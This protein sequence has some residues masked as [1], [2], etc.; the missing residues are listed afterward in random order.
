MKS[1]ILFFAIFLLALVSCDSNKTAPKQAEKSDFDAFYARF[2]KDSL[3][4]MAHINFPLPGLPEHPDSLSNPGDFRWY[5]EDW[6]MHRPIDLSE[7]SGFKREFSVVSE[8][9]INEKIYHKSGRFF[10]E[11]RFAKMGKD[12][13]LIYYAAMQAAR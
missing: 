10:M 1:R 11:R 13:Y 4:Q 7:E 2:H 6:V 12:W 8:D 5:K 3:Y 9:L